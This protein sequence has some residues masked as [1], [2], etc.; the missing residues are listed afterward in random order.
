MENNPGRDYG[1]VIKVLT[2]YVRENTLQAPEPSKESW[3]A[4]SMSNGASANADEGAG[5]PAWPEAVR[6]TA[7]IQ[8]ILDVLGRALSRPPEEY[9]YLTRVFRI[10]IDL[11][12][13]KLRGADLRG[14][15]LR[16]ANLQSANLQGADLQEAK[17]TD[18]QLAAAWSLQGATMPE[19]K[20]YEDW[21]KD[22]EEGSGKDVENE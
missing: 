4:A 22:K 11:H 5:Q 12:E 18:E 6:P 21:I 20:K 1:T 9:L 8:A 17:V 7:D 16:L 10:R 13:A 14:A 3:D 15:D 19:G 2:A